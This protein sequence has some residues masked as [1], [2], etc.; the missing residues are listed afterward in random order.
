M[1]D[2]VSANAQRV[3]TPISELVA[4]LAA[5]KAANGQFTAIDL[6]DANYV[7]ADEGLYRAQ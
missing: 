6:L 2:G 3:S 5:V 7:R 4:H 1:P